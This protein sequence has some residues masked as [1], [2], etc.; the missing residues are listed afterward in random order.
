MQQITPE[1][2][3]ALQTLVMHCA[4][5]AVV[6]Q[7]Q[8]EAREGG[9]KEIAAACETVLQALVPF[10]NAT[11]KTLS[12]G[13]VPA[14]NPDRLITDLPYGTKL[15]WTMLLQAGNTLLEARAHHPPEHAEVKKWQAAFEDA[16]QKLEQRVRDLAREKG[17]DTVSKMNICEP[18][19]HRLVG[20][21]VL[22]PLSRRAECLR[23]PPAVAGSGVG[24]SFSSL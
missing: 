6:R 21:V 14:G 4:C 7:T 17:P 15:P 22:P 18:T 9:S 16:C 3:T 13:N 11:L 12:I 19:A 1:T 8:R 24:Y 5:I 23:E 20:N 10:D 2:A